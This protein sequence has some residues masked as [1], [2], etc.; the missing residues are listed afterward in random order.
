[1][2]LQ[3]TRKLGLVTC[4]AESGSQPGHNMLNGLWLDSPAE[5]ASNPACL[6]SDRLRPDNR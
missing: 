1:M 6:M 2:K 5:G 3:V 4:Q